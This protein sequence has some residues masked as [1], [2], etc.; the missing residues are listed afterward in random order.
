MQVIEKNTSELKEYGKNPRKNDEA[1]KYVGESI[2][3]FG[4]KVPIIIDKD[5]VIVAGHTRLKA[6]KRLKLKTVPCI[7]ADDL[8]PAQ[9]KAF[10]L[11]DNK[12][13]EIAEWDDVLLA[14]ELSDIDFDMEL[15]GF[16]LIYSEDFNDD[17][18]LPDGDKKP[19][20]QMSITVHNKQLDLINMAISYVYK[21]G[22]VE[23]Y[24]GNEN[25]NGNGVYEVIRQW[26]E[27][28]KLL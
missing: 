7:V 20:T 6:A 25:K 1:V 5:N 17:F 4:F 9:I 15:F 24:E 21:Q 27:Q 14:E 19:F 8:T 13:G 3:E 10:R 22:Q 12:V 18:S 28:K 2:K 16:E 23:K 26:A 11:A